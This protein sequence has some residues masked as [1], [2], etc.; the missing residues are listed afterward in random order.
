MVC[1]FSQGAGLLGSRRLTRSHELVRTSGGVLE[2]SA[3]DTRA[4]L[5]VLQPIGHALLNK[6]ACGVTWLRA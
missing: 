5:N 2:W 3:A 1:L 4:A 6:D